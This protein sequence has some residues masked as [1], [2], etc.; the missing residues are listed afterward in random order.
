MQEIGPNQ[1]KWLKALESGEYSQQ[2]EAI[3]H[4]NNGFCC[5]GVA[6]EIFKGE[7]N[8]ETRKDG[9]HYCYGDAENYASL[10]HVIKNYLK[11]YTDLGD[12]KSDVG[13]KPLYIMN[14]EMKLPFDA[15]AKHIRFR[16]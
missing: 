3:L 8:L 9:E 1:E 14:D 6:C 12:P 7:L 5:L 2:H 4:N 16:S 13:N 11:L 15:I 10:P